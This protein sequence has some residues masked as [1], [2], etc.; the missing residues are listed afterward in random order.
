[1]KI[2]GLIIIA[3]EITQCTSIKFDKHP[4]FRIKEATF[5]NWV[6]GMPGVKGVNIF[7]EYTSKKEIV[8][9]SIFFA[10]RIVKAK[11]K[12]IKDKNF[13]I[14]SI[15][16]STVKSK[17]DLILHLNPKKEMQNKIPSINKFPFKL[18]GNEA[19]ISYKEA[20]KIKYFKVKNIKKTKAKYFP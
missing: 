9:D 19:V 14:G 16:F 11:I 6:G 4:P 5:N 17:E 2:L 12:K 20:G 8:F 7:F 10:N 3:L 1:M 15:N 18:K 13:V